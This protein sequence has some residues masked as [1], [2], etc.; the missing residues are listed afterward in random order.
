LKL[1]DEFRV[2]AVGAVEQLEGDRAIEGQ[3]LSPIDG[4]HAARAEFLLDFK[5]IE[6]APHAHG[7][8]AG[9]AM[10]EREGLF[11]GDVEQC[12]ASRAFLD[13]R[14]FGGNHEAARRYHR[15]RRAARSG[16]GG[17]NQGE[18]NHEGSKKGKRKGSTKNT[19]GHERERGP[20]I[21]RMT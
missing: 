7:P 3:V 20:R 18:W 15:P 19:K 6:L 14:I 8:A 5:V 10:H 11:A 17:G 12:A 13:E 1:R 21:T 4:A 16:L 9:R 2:F